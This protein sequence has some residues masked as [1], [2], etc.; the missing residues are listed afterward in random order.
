MKGANGFLAY[1]ANRGDDMEMRDHKVSFDI[2][3]VKN[4]FY[5][6]RD[7]DSIRE[8]IADADVVVNLIGKYYESGQP[9]QIPKFPYLSYQTRMRTSPYHVRLLKSVRKCRLII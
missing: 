7:H 1:L 2:G 5:S 6:P 4:V 8:V 9:V 3:R